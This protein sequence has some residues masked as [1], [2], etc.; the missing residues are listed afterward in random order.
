MFGWAFIVVWI[1]P[2]R[3]RDDPEE[4]DSVRDAKPLEACGKF[5]N[6]TALC[7]NGPNVLVAMKTLVNK[8]RI[9]LFMS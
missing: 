3:E 2:N 8:N 7:K 4:Y 1:I 6:P 5:L 9:L